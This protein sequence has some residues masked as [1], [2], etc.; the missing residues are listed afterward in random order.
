MPTRVQT[1][2][3]ARSIGFDFHYYKNKNLA[4]RPTTEHSFS[5]NA[6]LFPIVL[7]NY[8]IIFDRD[9]SEIFR[10]KIQNWNNRFRK[11]EL[12]LC[13]DLYNRK[14]PINKNALEIKEISNY[15]QKRSDLMGFIPR[16]ILLPR[17]IRKK[18]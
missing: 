18:F 2:N 13:L 1:L 5:I 9:F 17:I 15:C 10:K 6:F 3:K 12:I 8:R 16:R 11:D 7:E 4:D 14:F